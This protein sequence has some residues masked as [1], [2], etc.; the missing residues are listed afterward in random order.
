MKIFYLLCGTPFSGKTTLAK[1]IAIETQSVHISTDD[2]MRQRGFDLAQ[3]Q[4]V[5]EWAR[6]HQVCVQRVDALMN[7]GVSI[8]RRG[9]LS[10][11]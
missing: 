6:T 2:I 8:I 5:E 7:E 4:P 11:H 10:Y 1:R 3:L 9:F